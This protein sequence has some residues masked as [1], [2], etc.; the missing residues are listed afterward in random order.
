[1]NL[2]SRPEFDP[3]EPKAVSGD[4]KDPGE[5]KGAKLVV[6]TEAGILQGDSVGRHR[7]TFKTRKNYQ[8]PRPPPSTYLR[9]YIVHARR[10][11][12]FREEHAYPTGFYSS[13][14]E[15]RPKNVAVYYYIKIN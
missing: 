7:H 1:M 13:G 12:K 3:H 5:K 6:R 8:P 2:C 10:I 11:Q 15:T 9:K 14:G 4:R